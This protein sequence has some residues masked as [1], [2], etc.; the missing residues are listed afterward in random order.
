MVA[1]KFIRIDTNADDLAAE[2]EKVGRSLA[3]APSGP[4]AAAFKD[5]REILM[6]DVRTAMTSQAFP[7]D[8]EVTRAYKAREGLDSRTLFAS[9]N[10]YAGLDGASGM[11]WAKAMRGQVEWYIFLHDRGRGYGPWSREG[12]GKAK[13]GSRKAGWERRHRGDQAAVPGVTN[14]PQRQVFAI[15]EAARGRIIDRLELFYQSL[16]DEVGNAQ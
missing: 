14:F 11:T 7:P 8:S 16:V 15:S 12:W 9:G 3:G 5:L 1:G 10:A 4:A 13:D 6:A 2:L